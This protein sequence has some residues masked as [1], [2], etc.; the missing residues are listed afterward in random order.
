MTFAPSAVFS[1]GFVGGQVEFRCIVSNVC[2]SVTSNPATLTICPAD[3]DDGLGNGV[4]DG[5]VDISDLVYFLGKFELG[6]LA[7]DLDD[8]SGFGVPDSGV[9]INDLLF[10]LGHFEAGC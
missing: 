10:F 2:D 5:G 6:D 3:T 8:G 1:K 4:C 9:D 7:A